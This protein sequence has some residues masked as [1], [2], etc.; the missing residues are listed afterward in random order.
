MNSNPMYM[1]YVDD[2]DPAPEEHRRGWRILGWVAIGLSVTL[3]CSSLGLYGYYRKLNGNISRESINYGP[4]PEKLNDALN[5]LLLG[6]DTR[7]GANA[8]YGR[9]MVN[10][11]PRSDTMILLH[12]S[13]GGE[14][15]MGISFP[16]D[17]MV[18]I[19]DCKA[20]DGST[21]PAS[22]VAMINES[23][24]RGGAPCTVK[25]IERLTQIK[26]DHF[27]Q[28][29][30]VGFKNITNAI[31]G[32]DVCV[33]KNVY[34]PQAKLRLSKGRHTIKGETALAY[35]RSRKALGD[36]SDLDRI[37]RQQQFMASL[38]K[39]ALS[40]GV[41]SNPG[42]LNSLL[43][44]TTKSLTADEDLDVAAM[45]KIARG[46]QGLTAGKLRFVTVPWTAYAPDPNRVA[47]RQPDANQ[48]FTAIRH[49]TGIQE[50]RTGGTAAPKIPPSQ[51]RVR[52]YNASGVDGLARRVA[53]ELTDRGFR[54]VEVG[55][56]PAG[57]NTQVLYGPGADHQAAAL[58]EVVPDAG[59]PA[60]G[61]QGAAPGMVDL[62]LGADWTSLKPRQSGIPRQQD[63]VRATDDICKS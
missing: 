36:G 59:K 19:P 29:D 6:S 62:V 39:K 2:A 49:D 53:D 54:V 10:D 47:L 21:V 40:A 5:I 41:L 11:P 28:V 17:L 52:V 45:T 30:F 57:R 7:T 4:R 8:K 25:T 56:R 27:L 33:P 31:G 26:I 58:A 48:F 15:A 18:P 44:A 63:E 50:T 43:S 1:E 32:V 24:T 13:P 16:R 3:V 42:T 61:A 22:S 34:D 51:V 20:R 14:Q 23:F 38:A 60:P 12:L 46:M 9:S 37:K 55:N 35:V